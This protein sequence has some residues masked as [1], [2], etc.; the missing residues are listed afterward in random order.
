MLCCRSPF[1]LQ[2]L[3]NRTAINQPVN[4]NIIMSM[5][6]DKPMISFS[7]AEFSPIFEPLSVAP[8]IDQPNAPVRLSMA[9]ECVSVCIY[10]GTW[11]QSYLAGKLI[12]EVTGLWSGTQCI[13]SMCVSACLWVFAYVWM[14]VFICVSSL[15]QNPYSD[16]NPL[17]AITKTSERILIIWPI[18]WD[19]GTHTYKN[20]HTLI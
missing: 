16:P 20:T 17:Q 9:R 19:M 5:S 13:C 12:S 4:C 14:C 1:F 3:T 8:I 15:E 10:C 7:E 2:C 11:P 18:G 6:K